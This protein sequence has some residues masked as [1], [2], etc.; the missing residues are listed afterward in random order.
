VYAYAHAH[1]DFDGLLQRYMETVDPE[2]KIRFLRGLA[3]V[4]SE[5]SF[6]R[7]LKLVFDGTLKARDGALV[8]GATAANPE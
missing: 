2:E 8:I 1:A 4:R 3:S 7:L 5:E 6:N